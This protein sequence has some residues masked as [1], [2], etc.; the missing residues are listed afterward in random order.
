MRPTM[1]TAIQEAFWQRLQELGWIHGQNLA[2]DYRW[3]EWRFERL[4]AL[5]TELVQ[6]PVDLLLAG[7]ELEVLA[8]TQ[9]TSTIPIVMLFSLDAVDKDSS[10]ASRG[11][12]RTSRG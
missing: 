12:V 9:A 3:A 5:A 8:A 2:V 11:R 10:P 4:P 1:P 6:R 7:S